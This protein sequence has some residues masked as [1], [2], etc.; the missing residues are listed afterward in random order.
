MK[1]LLLV[2]AATGS[3]MMASTAMAGK[4]PAPTQS[5]PSGSVITTPSLAA[6]MSNVSLSSLA[7]TGVAGN[8]GLQVVVPV[9]GVATPAVAT[10]SGDV[11][12][13]TFADGSSETFS[14]DDV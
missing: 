13:V 2:V 9:G 10:I 8:G 5:Q 6:A 1:K 11:V 12:T 3:M 7:V 14:V 4:A